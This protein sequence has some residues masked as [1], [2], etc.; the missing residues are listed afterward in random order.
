MTDQFAIQIS[1]LSPII[2]G[3]FCL[4]VGFGVYLPNKDKRVNRLFLVFSLILT[5]WAYS[6]FVQSVATA[7]IIALFHDYI[8]YSAASFAPAVFF[9]LVLEITGGTSF[10]AICISYSVGA[11]FFIINFSPLFRKGVVLL[12]S[13]RYVTDPNIGWY[14]YVVFFIVMVAFAYYKTIQSVKNIKLNRAQVLYVYLANSV[15]VAGGASYFVLILKVL[16]FPIDLWANFFSSIALALYVT[17][18]AYSITRYRLMDIEVIFRKGAVYSVLSVLITVAYFLMVYITERYFSSII[19]L[20]LLW[21]QVPAVIV[22][23]VLFQPLKDRIQ[24]KTEAWFFPERPRFKKAVKELSSE[25]ITLIG[26][27][28]LK[29]FVENKAASVLGI[30]S[31]ELVLNNAVWKMTDERVLI[32]P[33]IGKIAQ[34]GSLVLGR[35]KTNDDYSDEEK[36]LL[37][38]LSNQI[39]IAIENAS[40]HREILE[41]QKQL[42]TSDKF[43]SLGRLTAGIAHEIRNP[44]AAIK[45]MVQMLGVKYDNGEFRKDFGD[46]VPKEIDRLS[47]LLDSLSFYS[48]GAP[49]ERMDTDVGEISGHVLKLYE[50]MMKE[51]GVSPVTDIQP[52]TT[53]RADKS[54]MIQVFSNLI[55]NAVQA[56]PNGGKLTIMAMTERKEDGSSM[57]EILVSDTGNG[58]PEEERR[59]IFEPFYTNKAFGTGLGLAITHKIIEEQGGTIEVESSLTSLVAGESWRG[60][61]FRIRFKTV[62]SSLPPLSS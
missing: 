13:N 31:A 16:E 53:I 48:K 35:K 36:D 42:L 55:L 23:V 2:A 58:I 8:L 19:G 54:G 32:I 7:P 17:I 38:T 50:K 6:C 15:L 44:L 43:A 1:R 52:S 4:F 5:V 56:M 28:D 41:H 60:T 47:C 40:L 21:I 61:T 22:L 39:A 37:A 62:A 24:S 51:H 46:V 14:L 49:G 26:I 11:A 12:F 34:L 9:Q 3:A 30:K 10:R 25:V 27:E 45:G 59:Y 20:N 29:R 18:T 57:T 33:V